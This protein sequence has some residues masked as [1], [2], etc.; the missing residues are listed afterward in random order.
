MSKTVVRALAEEDRSDTVGTRF[1]FD[2]VDD[3]FDC[4]N[5]NN[6]FVHQKKNKKNLEP[7]RHPFD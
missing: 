4:M 6:T 5:V 7:Y 3:F 1:F 2:M